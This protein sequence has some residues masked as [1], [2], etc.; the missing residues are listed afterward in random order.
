VGGVASAG[1]GADEAGGDAASGKG[2]AAL[3]SAAA[4]AHAGDPGLHCDAGDR[5][6]GC[7]AGGRGLRCDAAG[8][9]LRCDAG[10]RGLR[11]DAGG[12]GI[13]CD[14]G[15]DVQGA[16]AADGHIALVVLLPP[17][18]PSRRMKKRRLGTMEAAGMG[19]PLQGNGATMVALRLPGL[20]S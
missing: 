19:A 17:L 13:R 2:Y 6:L 15:P 9:G 1:A 16:L 18:T 14:A 10:G 11:C 3:A 8:R 20:C 5:G 7:D 12:R 4:P